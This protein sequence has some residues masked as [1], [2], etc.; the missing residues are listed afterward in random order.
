MEGAAA[1]QAREA[2]RP[3][4]QATQEAIDV[5]AQTA[6]VVEQQAQGSAD[7]KNVFLRPHEVPP[8]NIGWG[9]YVN[10]YTFALKSGVRAAHE[11]IRDQVEA[12]AREQYE[13]YTRST[14]ERVNSIQQFSPPP[15]FT[16][17]V[18]PAET[19]PV[20]KVEPIT[21][22]STRGTSTADHVP[23]PVAP[24]TPADPVPTPSPAVPTSSP[25]DVAP[26][27]PAESGSAWVAPAASGTPAVGGTAPAPT[28]GGTGGGVVGGVVAPPGGTGGRSGSTPPGGPGTGRGGGS[29][30]GRGTPGVPGGGGRTGTGSG[31]P[32]QSPTNPASPPARGSTSGA[33]VAGGPA[34]GGRQKEEEKEHGRKFV[35]GGRDAWE[36]LEI[37]KVA[38]P[39]FG[40]WEAEALRGKPPRPPEEA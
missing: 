14:N 1:D 12:Q 17:D 21:S 35:K 33:G 23:R 11:D 39:V 4:S 30:T 37:P 7:F 34:G 6:V 18:A 3:L 24:H 15:K 22:T 40:D 20:N 2:V 36:D 28:S 38:P 25:T 9:D 13:A 31:T 8:D 32:A 26:E 10:P 29:G 5:A 27:A 16:A 19:T